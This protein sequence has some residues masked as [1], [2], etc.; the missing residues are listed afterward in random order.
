MYGPNHRCNRNIG[1]WTEEFQD[2]LKKT[3][4]GIAGLGG[5][6]LI[7]TILARNGIGN[8]KIADPDVF[9]R[10]NIQR[11][12]Y[13]LESTVGRNKTVV[14]ANG[15][16]DINPEIN[17]INYEEG[18]TFDNL[19]DFLEGCDFLHDGMDYFVPDLKLEFHRKARERGLI[20]TTAFHVGTGASAITFHPKKGMCFEEYFGYAGQGKDWKM[21]H[22]K[23]VKIDPDYIDREFFLSRVNEGEIPTSCDAALFSSVLVTGIYKRLLMGKDIVYAP[24]MLRVDVVDDSL[25]KKLLM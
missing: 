5:Q 24:K 11:Q 18:I 14:T 15:L 22:D 16:K 3:T 23:I 6:G 2:K 19:E 9:E 8:L 17:I 21:D 4:I 7:A 25:Y 12:V 20:V 1:V 10:H 13:A